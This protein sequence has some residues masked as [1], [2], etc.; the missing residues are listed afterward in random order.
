MQQETLLVWLVAFPLIGALACL[1]FSERLS[2]IIALAF[3]MVG[4]VLGALLYVRF[5]AADSFHIQMGFV[6]PGFPPMES[7]SRSEWMG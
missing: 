5:N 1:P 7:S 6:V 3:T 2:K 4:L